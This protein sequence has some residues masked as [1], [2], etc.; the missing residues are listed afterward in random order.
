MKPLDWRNRSLL[1]ECWFIVWAFHIVLRSQMI[2]FFIFSSVVGSPIC[3]CVFISTPMLFNIVTYIRWILTISVCFVYT[4]N[5]SQW[6]FYVLFRNFCLVGNE[7]FFSSICFDSLFSS[8]RMLEACV[9]WF[10]NRHRHTLFIFFFF[11]LLLLHFWKRLRSL[12][13]KNQ[14]QRSLN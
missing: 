5:E 4:I 9:R 12:F 3:Q 6:S 13:S 8:Q 7:S 2:C 1:F 14:L 11:P 10:G